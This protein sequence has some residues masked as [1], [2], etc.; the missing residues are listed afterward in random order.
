MFGRV[1]QWRLRV[2]SLR[3]EARGRGLPG[4]RRA[5]RGAELRAR[6]HLPATPWTRAHEFGAAFLTELGLQL[7]RKPTART[8]HGASLLLRTPKGKET[9][10]ALTVYLSPTQGGQVTP[11]GLCGHAVCGWCREDS[12]FP[13]ATGR[14]T[15]SSP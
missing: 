7:I 6:A 14:L 4:E 3:R 1:A 2:R 9:A 8:V 10:C 12:G 13:T 15:H 5:T 11:S